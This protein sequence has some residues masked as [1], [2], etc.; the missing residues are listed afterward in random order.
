MNLQKQET[1]MEETTT[2]AKSQ[3]WIEE[4]LAEIEE[5]KDPEAQVDELLEFADKLLPSSSEVLKDALDAAQKIEDKYERSLALVAI[6]PN[7]PETERPKVLKDALDAAQKIEDDSYRS[8]ALA[9]IAP[10]LPQTERPKVLKDA[11]DAAQKIEDDYERFPALEA[12][13]ANLSETEPHTKSG[14]E[15][16][17]TVKVRQE[18]SPLPPFERGEDRRIRQEFGKSLFDN[19]IWNRLLQQ[20]VDSVQKIE[21]EEEQKLDEIYPD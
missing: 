19:Q 9:T 7:L 1:T 13:A 5:I 8:L 12:I 6:A 16:R 4:R 21:L 10:N 11:L 2:P 18:V 14:L 3:S 17:F 20:A 15:K